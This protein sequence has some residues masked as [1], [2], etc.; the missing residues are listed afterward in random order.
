MQHPGIGTGLHNISRLSTAQSRSI[1]AENPNGAKGRGA[2][3]A[4]E[5]NHPARE[6]GVGWKVRPCVTVEP[7]Q[8]LTIAEID[9]P[10][11]IEHIWLTCK[12]DFWRRLIIRFYWDDELTPSIE[13]PI[14]DLFCNGWCKPVAVNSLPIAVNPR[15][16]F[17]SYWEMPF[18]QKARIT[19][20]NL[21]HEPHT[22]LFYQVDYTLTDIPDDAAY[23]H[24]QWRRSNPVPY[25][26]IHTLVDGITG[27]GHYV[28]TYVAWQS[29]NDGWWGEGE[30]KFY[31]DG[32]EENPTICGTGTEDYFGGAWCFEVEG[33]YVPYSTPFLGFH[34]IL[35]PDGA[36]KSNMRFGM[37]RW[38]IPDPVRFAQDLRV[39]IQALGWRSNYRFLPL[40]DDIA[41]TTF[42]YQAEP[43]APFPA[44]GTAN[45]LEVI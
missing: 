34:Q 15:G 28:G 42:W 38:H 2:L 23:L 26:D 5:G 29:N 33:Q 20:E 24:A 25:G 32:D 30:I 43:H 21:W 13:A 11:A 39:T 45:E 41:S 19:V 35:K 12:S 8:V 1:S 4:P 22:G 27:H 16:G 44:I 6:L 37:Y 36:F 10:G 14:G 18:R 9:G 17:N 7:G 3:A 40:Q 31:I